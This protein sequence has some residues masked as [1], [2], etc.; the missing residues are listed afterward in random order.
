MNR[1]FA[2]FIIEAETP[3]AVGSDKL[4]YNQDMPVDKD[5]NG[6]PY[7]PGTALA[8]AFQ[9]GLAD[10]FKGLFGHSEGSQPQG[11]NLIFSDALL[12]DGKQVL[13][14]L[15]SD[16]FSKDYYKH[17]KELPVRPHARHDHKGTA[18]DKGLFD[19]EIVYKGARFKF[20]I[21][22]ECCQSSRNEIWKLFLEQAQSLDLF[23][24]AG[25]YKG[26]GLCTIKEI[27][28]ADCSDFAGFCKISSDLNK[29]SG[30]ENEEVLL[31]K[32]IWKTLNLNASD[33][34]FH[35]GAGY[36]DDDTDAL[37]YKE[38]VIIW[39]GDTPDLA[40]HY[41]IPATSIKGPVAHRVAYYHNQKKGITLESIK[42]RCTK[43]Q[44]GE[45]DKVKFAKEVEMVTG[46]NNPAVKALF[47][48]AKDR[49]E[50]KG[51]RGRVLFSDV[52]IPAES[53]REVKLMHNTIDRFT[54][55][56]KDTALFSEK[57][58]HINQLEI[59]YRI[60]P[61][62]EEALFRRALNDISKGTLPIGGMAAKGHGIL[63]IPTHEN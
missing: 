48:N 36:G 4:H 60:E 54:G 34:L 52:F 22:F 12:Y 57:A 13:Q 18:A 25:Q 24:G 31:Q 33:S 30:F 3:I 14:T 21:L 42:N 28:T 59:K 58:I 26:Y 17:F 16:V 47:G 39:N 37:C 41:V 55:G 44:T 2:R 62:E 51:D 45:L 8:G 11:S 38:S 63:T 46:E 10:D 27:K 5:F 7:I 1:Y 6:L 50:E 49:E 53:A 15:E 19:N 23:L 9:A 29:D 32:A 56:T 40:E 20:E 43:P 35:F 61:T